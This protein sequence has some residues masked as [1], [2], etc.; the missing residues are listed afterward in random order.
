VFGDMFT[1]GFIPHPFADFMEGISRGRWKGTREGEEREGRGEGG[2][3]REGGE[4]EG[5][6]REEGGKRDSAGQ[7]ES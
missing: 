4:R 3:R 7:C 5:R 1:I 2:E 6:G